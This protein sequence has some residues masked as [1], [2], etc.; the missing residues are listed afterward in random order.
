MHKCPECGQEMAMEE[1]EFS[2]DMEDSMDDEASL[3]TSVLD[4]LQEMLSGGLEE[5][6]KSKKKPAMMSVE[7]ASMKPKE[8][9]E[10]YE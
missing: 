1:K 5:K 4:E 3:K 7:I 8:D 6:L 10:D 2:P 9:E